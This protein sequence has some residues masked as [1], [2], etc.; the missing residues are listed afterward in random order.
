MLFVFLGFGVLHIPT[1][2]YCRRH[3]PQVSVFHTPVYSPKK[4][5]LVVLSRLIL[6]WWSN[7]VVPSWLVP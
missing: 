5:E 6:C 1:A 4:R 7:L 3:H 2:S